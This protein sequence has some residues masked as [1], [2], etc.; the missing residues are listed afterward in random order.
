MLTLD[1]SVSL[2]SELL[3][4]LIDAMDLIGCISIFLI[5]QV[6]KLSTTREESFAIVPDLVNV[7]VQF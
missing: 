7:V 3:S 6:I 5:P 4:N 2:L 1:R